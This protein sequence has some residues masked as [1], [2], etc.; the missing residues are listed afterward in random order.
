MELIEMIIGTMGSTDIINI[1]IMVI[2]GIGTTAFMDSVII[3]IKAIE[4]FRIIE[5]T[6]FI[7]IIGVNIAEVII[8]TDIIR[9]IVMGTAEDIRADIANK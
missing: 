4:D 9:D 2:M 6:I 1:G 5:E 3:G 7:M 8:I